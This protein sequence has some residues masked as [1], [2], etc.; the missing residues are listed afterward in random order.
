MITFIN[1]NQHN[2]IPLNT[3]ILY[4][5]DTGDKLIGNITITDFDDPRMHN[6]SRATVRLINATTL[7]LLRIIPSSLPHGIY[8]D[9]S[10]ST[11]LNFVGSANLSQYSHLLSSI[12]YRNNIEEPGVATRTVVYSLSDAD[13]TS[14]T[15]VVIS[16]IPRNDAPVIHNSLES[17]IYNEENRETLRLTN[18]NFTIIDTDSVQLQSATIIIGNVKPGDLLSLNLS[19]SFEFESSYSDS[20]GLLDIKGNGTLTD[21][22]QFLQSA[23]FV[24]LNQNISPEDR[25]IE[26]TVTDAE[27]ATSETVTLVLTII[28]FDDPPI[29]FSDIIVSS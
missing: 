8:L 3:E 1:D 12:Y 4:F 24:N 16:I 14:T 18:D 20:T 11:T 25:Y 9:S 15:E 10:N 26:F 5:E 29:C 13:F 27:G 7:E 21:Y 19:Q 6:Y 17:V 2:L 28:T 23:T 22:S